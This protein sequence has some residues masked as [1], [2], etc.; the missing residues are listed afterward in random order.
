MNEALTETFLDDIG[1]NL[2][3]RWLSNNCQCAT[4]K[5]LFLK[6]FPSSNKH[7]IQTSFKKTEELVGS[8]D[9]NEKLPIKKNLFGK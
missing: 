1:F 4:N 3:R 5:T 9:R 7:L 6:L 8:L 2:I